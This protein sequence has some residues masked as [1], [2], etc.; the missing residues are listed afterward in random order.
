M[1]GSGAEPGEHTFDEAIALHYGEW[2]LMKV[3]AHNEY[4]EP[5]RGYVLAHSPRR[6]DISE[7]LG[8]EPLRSE[9]P[10]GAPLYYIFKAYP[11]VHVGETFD[12]AAAR[13][14]QQRAAVA[15]AEHARGR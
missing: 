13:F 4:A 7:A 14:A 8:K 11:R 9:L 5:A 1:I 15:E 10:P 3:T 2:V 6:R 12:Q